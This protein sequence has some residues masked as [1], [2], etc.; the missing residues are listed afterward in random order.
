MHVQADIRD[1]RA[2][3]GGYPMIGE[4]LAEKGVKGNSTD[5]T[6]TEV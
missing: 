6:D 2:D 4:S 5:E 1:S 3:C